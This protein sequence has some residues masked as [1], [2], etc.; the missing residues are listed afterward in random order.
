MS[1]VLRV[2]GVGEKGLRGYVVKG[3]GVRRRISSCRFRVPGI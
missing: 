2:Q 1:G 3:L